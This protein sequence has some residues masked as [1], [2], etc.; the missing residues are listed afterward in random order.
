MDL[1]IDPDQN[2]L[3]AIWQGSATNTNDAELFLNCSNGGFFVRGTGYVGNN[4]W[5]KGEWFRLTHRVD[6]PDSSAIFINGVKVLSDDQLAG[7]DWLYGTGTDAPIW[8]L[9][10]DL[11]GNDVGFVRCA[12]IALVDG[13]LQDTD[14]ADLAGPDANGI[15]TITDAPNLPGDLNGDGVV[16]GGDLG[17]L[18]SFFG[19]SDPLADLNGDGTVNGADIGLLLSYWSG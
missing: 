2:E 16:N 1:F 7:D 10:D 8:L 18:L 15:F 3:Q 11:G 9:T 6:Y 13:L 4:L 19:S 14:L 5:P 17:L 12:N